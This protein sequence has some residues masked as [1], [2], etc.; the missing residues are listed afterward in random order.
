MAAYIQVVLREPVKNLGKSG[1]L[2]RV[3]PGFARN[4][5]VP[6]SLAV[7][8]TE[9]NVSRLEHE[10]R[11]A[12]A[13]A[14]K[15]RAEAEAIASK[16]SGVT[17]TIKRAVGVDDRMYGSVTARDIATALAEAGHV[18]DRRKLLLKEPIRTLGTH[19]VSAHLA[20]E[21]HATFKVEVIRA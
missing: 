19:E 13:R 7:Y 6:R 12:L 8:A 2:V 16:L 14:S 20:P 17:I 21:I 11:E 1:E 10:K 18:V 9:K 3:R 15:A 4:F 5:L